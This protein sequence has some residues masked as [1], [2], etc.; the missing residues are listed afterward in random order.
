MVWT[1]PRTGY[2]VVRYA[3]IIDE[4]RCQ[5]HG[6]ACGDSSHVI[7]RAIELGREEQSRVLKC[8]CGAFPPQPRG[9]P[10]IVR[11]WRPHTIYYHLSEDQP[12]SAASP[13]MR[14][15]FTNDKIIS[16][17]GFDTSTNQHRHQHPFI[18][19]F[20]MYFLVVV[21]HLRP[22]Q[23]FRLSIG[24]DEASCISWGSS[25]GINSR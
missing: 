22:H 6:L 15:G 13:K 9:D 24:L 23:S 10:N 11:D 12:G 8:G 4:P 14:Y 16:Q 21:V 7:R 5:G 17:S 2:L 1:V 25:P 19:F 18:T 3:S 20:K